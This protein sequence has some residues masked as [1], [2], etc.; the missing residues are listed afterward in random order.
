MTITESLK[1]IHIDPLLKES[2]KKPV[3]Y[4]MSRPEKRLNQ[5]GLA[6]FTKHQGPDGSITRR[7]GNRLRCRVLQQNSQSHELQSC[8]GLP[9]NQEIQTST[10]TKP[11]VAE[12]IKPVQTTQS[13]EVK[14][15]ELIYLPAEGM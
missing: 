13:T 3:R 8:T 1:Q 10:G 2:V 5:K 15:P 12:L 9:D 14:I 11:V 6:D 4:E 7:K